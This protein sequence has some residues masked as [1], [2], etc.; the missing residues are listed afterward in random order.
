MRTKNRRNEFNSIFIIFKFAFSEVIANVRMCHQ[1]FNCNANVRQTMARTKR[2]RLQKWHFVFFEIIM[3]GVLLCMVTFVRRTPDSHLVPPASCITRL[4]FHIFTTLNGLL[5]K[6]WFCSAVS[7]RH[8][9]PQTHAFL[10][11]K[12]QQTHRMCQQKARR[13]KMRRKCEKD[14]KTN[15]SWLD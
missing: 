1:Q 5:S 7:R 4:Q 11:V 13:K 12:C 9:T 14:Q 15:L 6:R 3:T 10:Y 2:H 8:S